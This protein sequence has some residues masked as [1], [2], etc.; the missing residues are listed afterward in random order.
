MRSHPKF[1]RA[2]RRANAQQAKRQAA[3]REKLE[4]AIDAIAERDVEQVHGGTGKA[5][6]NERIAGDRAKQRCEARLAVCPQRPDRQ[7]I[8]GRHQQRQHDGRQL[9]TI[10]AEKRPGDGEAGKS[11]K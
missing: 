3:A 9:E 7:D 11:T 2:K 5:G 1:L 10:A 8:D 4:Q 6:E